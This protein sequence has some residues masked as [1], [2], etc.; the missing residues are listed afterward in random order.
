LYRGSFFGCYDTLKT[1]GNTKTFKWFSAYAAGLM[2]SIAVYPVETI[3]K[4]MILGQNNGNSFITL[5]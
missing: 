1:Q 5:K 4:N 3:R 2:G